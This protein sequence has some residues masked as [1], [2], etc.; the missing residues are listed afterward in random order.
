MSN[1]D[2]I[3]EL[4]Q[5]LYIEVLAI[6]KTQDDHTRILDTHTQILETHSQIL[7]THTQLHNNHNARFDIIEDLIRDNL[8]HSQNVS[9]RVRTLE[10]H[11]FNE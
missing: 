2:Q 1:E 8:A 11:V 4:L 9:D 3:L 7:D 10:A 6:K 5:T